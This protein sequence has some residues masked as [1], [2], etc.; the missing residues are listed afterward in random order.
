LLLVLAAVVSA[1][2]IGRPPV[3]AA[4]QNEIPPPAIDTAPGGTQP[5]LL[6]LHGAGMNAHMWDPVLPHLDPAYRAVAIDLPGHGARR[7]GAFTIETT[8]AAVAAAAKSVA[9]APVILVGD[10]LGGY[11]AMASAASLPQEQLRGLV[12]SG[13]TGSFDGW[14]V[15]LRYRRDQVMFR[16]LLAVVDKQEFAAK[17][18]AKYEIEEPYRKRIMDAG[19]N[20]GAVEVAVEALLG[21]DFRTVVAN[22]PQPILFLNGSLDE[23]AVDQEASFLAAAPHAT[24]VRFEGVPHGIS[25]RRPREFAEQVNRFAA[26]TLAEQ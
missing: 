2:L 10:S 1:I 6:L 17:A 24:S 4:A 22:I 26:S 23:R 20:L 15:Y 21:I 16:N 11:S 19:M 12:L 13:C 8:R 7:A 14:A 5:V 3:S 9:P 25:V 18:L